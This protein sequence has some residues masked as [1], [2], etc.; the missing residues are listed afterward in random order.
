M[1]KIAKK[2]DLWVERELRC[3]AGRQGHAKKDR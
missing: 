1:L 3:T 2:A